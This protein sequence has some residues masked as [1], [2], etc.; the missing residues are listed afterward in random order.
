MS[1]RIAGDNLVLY[2][3]TSLRR[4]NELPKSTEE[5]NSA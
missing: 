3:A 1:L 2:T 4:R 5:V